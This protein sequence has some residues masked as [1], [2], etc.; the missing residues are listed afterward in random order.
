MPMKIGT[1]RKPKVPIGDPSLA[2]GLGYWAERFLEWLSVQNYSKTSVE[3]RRTHLRVF[4]AWCTERS[5]AL[6]REVSKPM[7]ERYQRTLFYRRQKDGKPLSVRTQH[8]TLMSLKMFFRHL[9]KQNV[10]DANPA[11]DL[12]MPR[13]PKR[14]PP[15]VLTAEDMSRVLDRP[16]VRTVLGLRDRAALELLYCTAMR[17]FEACGLRVEDIDITRRVVYVRLGK[18]QK[19]RVLPLTERALVWIRRYQDEARP[20]LAGHSDTRVLLVSTTGEQLCPATLSNYV[21]AYIREA[22]VGKTGSCHLIRHSVAC[23]M[24]DAGASI[25]HIQE[26][27]GHAHLSTTQIYTQVSIEALR[28][29]HAAT[30]P[31]A[32]TAHEKAA[33]H[34]DASEVLGS[35]ADEA[36]DDGED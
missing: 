2:D 20:R 9:T 7:L 10:I 14:L 12:D 32:T 5:V 26:L 19:D 23:A 15:A 18:G 31:S 22:N 21:K 36:D 1:R 30:H 3:L 17:R 29:V 24:L 28:A 16:D 13:L 34:E 33:A 8:A 11:A 35:L 6:P 27:L 25:R 4:V